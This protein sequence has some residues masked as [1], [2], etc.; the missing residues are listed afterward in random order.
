MTFSE[1]EIAHAKELKRLGFAQNWKPVAGHYLSSRHCP[2]G[3]IEIEAQVHLVIQPSP[4]MTDEVWLPRMDDL[5][6]EAKNRKISFSQ[7]TDFLHRRRFA[8]R[9]EREG[10]MLLLIELLR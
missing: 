6:L 1:T 2:E 9:A 7:I 3:C 4:S 10:L 5:L 8:D